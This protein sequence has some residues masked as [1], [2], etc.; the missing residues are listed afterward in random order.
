M[1]SI[2]DIIVFVLVLGSIIFIHELG[3]FLAAKSFG[4]YCSEFA[5]GMGPKI[6][7]KKGKETEYTLRALPVG[8]FVAMYGEADQEVNDVFKGVDPD[9]SLKNIKTYQKVIVMLAG[10]FMNFLMAFAI[11]FAVYSLQP[12]VVDLPIIGSVVENS[13]AMQ[14]GLQAG[15]EIAA[16]EINGEMIEPA[17]YN[18]LV[19]FIQSFEYSGESTLEVDVDYLSGDNEATTVV[20]ALYNEDTKAYLLGI[21]A[22]TQRLPLNEAATSATKSLAYVSLS[23]LETL[24][25]VVTGDQQT[26]NQVS[27]PVGIF[28]ITSQ[29]RDQGAAQLAMVV[30]MLSAN[31]GIFNLLPIPGLDGSQAIFALVEKAIGREIPIKIRYFLQLAGLALVFGLMIL[32]TVKDITKIF[33]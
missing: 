33:S 3:H 30:A 5:L 6:F 11:I 20:Y 31:I 12:V 9:R 17:T 7:S 19:G 16:V 18:E 21:Q 27:G 1:D 15:D 22:S 28:N 24:G 23:V 26:I 32:I 13:P 2:I 29:V 4:V 10:V 25:K 14:A 8:G